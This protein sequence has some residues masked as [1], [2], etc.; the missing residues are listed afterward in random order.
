MRTTRKAVIW[1][2]R[3]AACAGCAPRLAGMGWRAALLGVTL[4]SAARASSTSAPAEGGA[5]WTFTG[6][7]GARSTP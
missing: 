7:G 4:V 2:Q 5:E 1:R 3:H 6:P